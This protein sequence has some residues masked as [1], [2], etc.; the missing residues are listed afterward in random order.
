MFF[1]GT[2]WLGSS[3]ISIRCI[4][5]NE[6]RRSTHFELWLIHIWM[7]ELCVVCLCVLECQL[8]IGVEKIAA[9]RLVRWYVLLF[10]KNKKTN[11]AFIEWRVSLHIFTSCENAS[12]VFVVV[13]ILCFSNV[14]CKSLWTKLSAKYHTITI[15]K[16]I[17]A[18]TVCYTLKPVSISPS[19]YPFSGICP[20]ILGFEH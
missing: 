1:R 9:L 10:Q 8:V 14:F 11:L 16:N 7:A 5:H 12:L 15:L 2:K 17:F 3:Y 13:H 18:Y 4:A 19:V 20:R 6:W